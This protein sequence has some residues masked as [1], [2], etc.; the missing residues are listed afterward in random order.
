MIRYIGTSRKRLLNQPH[1]V[2]AAADGVEAIAAL[3]SQQFDTAVIDLNMPKAS[4]IAA[5]EAAR[6]GGPNIN[7]PIIV[8]TG[9]DDATAIDHAYTAGATSFLTKP[10]NW[11]LFTPHV[12]FVLRSGQIENEL[13]SATAAAAFL[14][15][16]KSQM[17]G[18]LAREFQSPIKTIFGFSELIRKEVYGPLSPPMYREM[19]TDMGNAAQKL[20]VAF[21]S[22]LNFG[23][24]L[25]EQLQ[26]KTEPVR[27]ADVIHHAI[28]KSEDTA[29]RNS[30][31][32]ITNIELPENAHLE[33]DPVLLLQAVRSVIGNAIKVAPRG[34]SVEIHAGLVS[35]G[36][37]RLWTVDR[38]PAIPASLI[39]EI[40]PP[41]IER[42]VRS[43]DYET[44][45]VGIKIAKILTEA[46]QGRLDV[47]SDSA[48][49]NVVMLDIPKERL[50]APQA[51][52]TSSSVPANETQAQ[53]LAAVSLAL[54][55]DPRIRLGRPAEYQMPTEQPLRTNSPAMASPTVKPA[56]PGRPLPS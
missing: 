42:S 20:N 52:A 18:A 4:G 27:I 28:A 36:N 15:G 47:S 12:N 43:I 3:A 7:T 6:L 10:L 30:V 48:N 21:L 22:L 11:V 37:F 32:L 1:T 2:T 51:E 54:S 5:I 25:T 35:D 9:H 16:L 45:D 26:L 14:S 23:N 46:H 17:M 55:A 50:R 38:G 29:A 40:N 49:G 56:V 44:R 31:R 24:S 39:A 13:R 19:A 34:S 53:R 33:A 41:V 8:V